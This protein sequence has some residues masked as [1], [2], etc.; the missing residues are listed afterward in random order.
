MESRDYDKK[1]L[2][3]RKQPRKYQLPSV[4]KSFTIKGIFENE[5]NSV[6]G[7]ENMSYLNRKT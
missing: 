4:K 1:L 6:A 2:S 5:R 3:A 7:H